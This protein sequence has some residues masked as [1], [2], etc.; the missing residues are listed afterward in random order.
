MLWPESAP[1]S[2][3]HSV[4]DTIYVL[5][6]ELDDT[7]VEVVGNALRIDP[8]RCASDVA[9]FQAA[10]ESGD[11]EQA[12]ELYGGG[13]LDGLFLKNALEFEEWAREERDR[14][15]RAYAQALEELAESATQ[16]GDHLQ[17]VSWW[18]DLV[19][20]DPYNG[21]ATVRL[22]E[23][24]AAAGD[25]AEALR[26]ADAHSVQ[27]REAFNAA[28]DGAVTELAD[29]LR[30]E[31]TDG[32]RAGTVTTA[33]GRGLP[34]PWSTGRR[35]L[36][37]TVVV[38]ILGLAGWYIAV[39]D[40]GAGPEQAPGAT[41]APA[42]AVL[43]F[44]VRGEELAVLREGMVDLLSTGLD[45]A[46][47]LRTIPASTLLV[48]WREHVPGEDAPEL[49]TALE[50]A[51]RARAQYALV[52]S[53]VAVDSDV[54]IVVGI[55]DVNTNER[56][57]QAQVEGS[58]DDVLPLVDRLAVE[59]LQVV[60]QMGEEDLPKINLASVMSDTT[61]A[62]RAYLEGEVYSRRWDMAAAE[63]AYKRAIEAD[64]TF[65]LAH[66][67]LAKMYQWW[68]FDV[69]NPTMAQQ[70][71][72]R[73]VLLAD[74]LPARQAVVVRALHGFWHLT[75][76]AVEPLRQA[77]QTYPDDADAW[78]LLGE[79]L[80]HRPA[81]LATA[82]EID[83]AFEQAVELDP[84][85]AQYLW[86]YVELAWN[87]HGDSAVAVQR[88]EMF[89]RVAPGDLHARAG[90]LAL[91]VAFGDSVVQT[92]AM[93]RLRSEENWEVVRRAGGF[94]IHPRYAAF[95]PVLRLMHERG[96]DNWRSFSA[97]RLFETNAHWYGR[98]G[99]ALPYLDDPAITAGWR[100]LVAY[101]AF[102]VG[103]PIPEE[104]L[105]QA[106]DPALIDSV[107]PRWAVFHAGAFAADRGRWSDHADAIV[108]FERRA[109]RAL[110]ETDSVDALVNV[111]AVRALEGYGLWQRGQPTDAL[112]MLEDPHAVGLP[113]AVVRPWLGQL[114]QELGRLRDAERVYRSFIAADY[115]P[116]TEPLS[117]RQLGEI[118]EQLEEYDK[119]LESYEY[120]VEYWQDADPELQPMVEEARQAI[121]RLEGLQRE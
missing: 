96:D 22:M 78:Y 10:I 23:S 52:G 70:H 20:H 101:R 77:V 82:E 84:R 19:A 2:A 11:L 4:R 76:D 64:S 13:F 45:G 62:L 53:V 26:Q 24:L 71:I 1:E 68:W 8:E 99:E 58:P 14:F 117:Q 93:T 87:F 49:A 103:L 104:T 121:I 39:K 95:Q 86:H 40:Q 118:Y 6:H 17:A 110:G 113:W 28:P 108:E 21:R 67:Q 59:V 50:V 34:L 38:A 29:R 32:A 46:G 57:G 60:L 37:I 85:N 42:I 9:A 43:P 7:L 80:Y 79:F 31:P 54:R 33:A 107:A 66:Y 25:R 114:Y 89:E 105:E 116:L 30:A 27:M 98:L 119:A 56:L 94:L 15:S 120:F 102:V 65:A 106:L 81:L 3:H 72:S 69:G 35:W 91:D 97:R 63:E 75:P 88:L 115:R 16:R 47:G 112:P 36:S 92:V 5:N 18:R 111:G 51:R 48:R 73:A 61:A 55:Y 100:A 41:A 109:E 90:R 12:V 44:S 83:Q 74:R